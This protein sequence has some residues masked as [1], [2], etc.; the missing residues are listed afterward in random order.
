MDV[1]DGLL[2]SSPPELLTFEGDEIHVWRAALDLP[3]ERIQKLEQVLI[4]DERRRAAQFRFQKD[5]NHFIVARG[6]L[7]HILGRYLRKVPQTLSFTYNR[8][9]KPMLVQQAANDDL[10]FN[11]THSH[12]LALYAFTRLGNI[13]VDLEYINPRVEYDQLAERFFSPNEVRMLRSVPQ[14][15]R[16]EAFFQCWTRKEAYVKARGLGLSLDLNLFDVSLGPDMP[17][18]IL[19]IREEKQN[20]DRWSLYAL[21]PGTSYAGALAVEG[22]PKSIA[23]WQYT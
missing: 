6:I 1:S 12:E 4:D 5:R 15:T 9:G 17:A 14:E 7:R 20:V 21:S 23:H 18:A 13:G 11:V 16:L 22:H 3:I 19:G 10:F 8:Y 2:W